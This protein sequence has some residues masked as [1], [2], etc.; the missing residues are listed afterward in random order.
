MEFDLGMIDYEAAVG[1]LIHASISIFVSSSPWEP[2]TDPAPE[3]NEILF[4]KSTSPSDCGAF[5]FSDS[6]SISLQVRGC[7]RF[8]VIS[9]DCTG[10]NPLTIPVC[11]FLDTCSTLELTLGYFWST[12][13]IW[14][15]GS[16]FYFACN[17]SSTLIL[18]Y[19]KDSS[20]PVDCTFGFS[21]LFLKL[22]CFGILRLSC[23]SLYNSATSL[24]LLI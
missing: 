9:P 18:S 19:L 1:S 16:N 10:E 12:S 3:T 14:I 23:S 4:L 21:R 13:L 8:R 2:F 15:D 20:L 22:L 7:Y 6:L 17:L 24:L 11:T 5:E